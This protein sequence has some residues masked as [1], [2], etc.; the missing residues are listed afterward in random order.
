MYRQGCTGEHAVLFSQV[1]KITRHYSILTR[2]QPRAAALQEGFGEGYST[3]FSYGR[4]RPSTP[5]LPCVYLES[6][7]TLPFAC[8]WTIERTLETPSRVENISV[9]A[10]SSIYQTSF[11]SGNNEERRS[12]V[13]SCSFCYFRGE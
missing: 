7:R 1:A 6:L 5:P 9:A 2:I 11:V 3:P 4:T 12:R 8:F 13:T 10:G